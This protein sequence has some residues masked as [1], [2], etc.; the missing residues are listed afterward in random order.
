M[1]ILSCKTCT[2]CGEEKDL[3]DFSKDPRKL[4]G[5]ASRCQ[6]CA[7]KQSKKWYERNRPRLIERNRR[8]NRKRSGVSQEEYE[9]MFAKQNGRCAL[10]GETSSKTL[11]MDHD[12]KHHPN[13]SHDPCKQCIR[14]LLC[15]TCNRLVLPRLEKYP[16]LQNDFIKLY[17]EQRPL[18]DTLDKVLDTV[19]EPEVTVSEDLQIW[20]PGTN[21]FGQELPVDCPT[22]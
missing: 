3:T 16:H 4:S 15:N 19:V 11:D 7:N 8:Y 17:L 20:I 2:I 18:L 9:W 21:T 13:Q 10:C 5:Y 12:H 1:V 14:G 22:Q 6:I